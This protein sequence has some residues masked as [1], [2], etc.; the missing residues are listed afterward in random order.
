MLAD[1]AD[2]VVGQGIGRRHLVGLDAKVHV[3][4]GVARPRR[5]LRRRDAH[6]RS[7]LRR[8]PLPAAKRNGPA[9]AHQEAIAG[10]DLVRRDQLKGRPV[11]DPRRRAVPP[12]RKIHEQRS[13]RLPLRDQQRHVAGEIDLPV[14]SLGQAQVGDPVIA[15]KGRIHRIVGD[16]I[17]PLVGPATAEVLVCCVGLAADDLEFC[18]RHGTLRS[19]CSN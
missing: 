15:G 17:N 18:D 6:T 7:G 14:L 16:C 9:V 3:P 8:I 13:V 2:M 11:E 10:I 12:V 4:V 5:D 19:A 1:R